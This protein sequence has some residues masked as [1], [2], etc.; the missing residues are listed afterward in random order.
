LND[1][2]EENRKNYKQKSTSVLDLH[3]LLKKSKE[4]RENLDYEPSLSSADE[5]ITKSRLKTVHMNS[6]NFFVGKRFVLNAEKLFKSRTF[7]CYDDH[8]EVNKVCFSHDFIKRLIT[9]GMTV[10]EL[11]FFSGITH[12]ERVSGGNL[13]MRSQN[14]AGKISLNMYYFDLF[15]SVYGSE[16]CK[17]K[18][19]KKI[20]RDK[21]NEVNGDAIK[22][23]KSEPEPEK[24]NKKETIMTSLTKNVNDIVNVNKEAAKN[25]A[26]I[27]VGSTANKT[28][29]DIIVKTV[30]PKKYQKFAKS[31]FFNLVVANTTA[32]AMKQFVPNSN[33]KTDAVA[34][35]MIL[36]SMIEITNMV[37]INSIVKQVMESV[38]LSALTGGDDEK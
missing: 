17:S 11:G 6:I 27:K 18:D 4:M 14:A 32:I 15:N 21:Q 36:A 7:V 34:D 38:D 29:S 19:L 23:L 22:N 1:E 16:D 33:S 20:G 28:V 8:I 2:H 9:K 31:P 10:K 5:V 13:Y 12:I 3:E 35:A 24:E 30:L 25:A 37:D 26:M